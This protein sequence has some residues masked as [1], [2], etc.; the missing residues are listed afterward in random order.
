MN[1]LTALLTLGISEP[2]VR[3]VNSLPISAENQTA[4]LQK[5]VR[6]LVWESEDE[7]GRTCLKVRVLTIRIFFEMNNQ[8]LPLWGVYGT[9]D[10][11]R[12]M[13]F[14][15]SVYLKEDSDVG[16]VGADV[17]FAQFNHGK[18]TSLLQKFYEETT[19]VNGVPVIREVI[20]VKF[21]SLT[22]MGYPVT[23]ISS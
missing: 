22:D 12:Q 17:I 20:Q 4:F 14:H 1:G 19:E 8:L 15:L 18:F 2:L 13:P 5:V 3:S 10:Q 6:G 9:E 23:S 16:E 21:V 7:N 11:F